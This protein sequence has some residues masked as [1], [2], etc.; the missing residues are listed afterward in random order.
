MRKHAKATSEEVVEELMVNNSVTNGLPALS[1]TSLRRVHGFNKLEPEPKDHIVVRYV[2]QFK[3]PLIL[4]LLGSAVLSV[5]VGQYEDALSIAAAVIIVGSV[6]FYQAS[7]SY[8]SCSMM[9]IMAE[10]LV[11]GDIVR[12]QSGDRVPADARIIVCNNLT[13]DESTLTGETE[14]RE[15]RSDPLPDLTD[16]CD[17]SSISNIAFM[18]TLI[19]SGNA[20]GIV[21]TTALET[22]FGKTFK[23]MKVQT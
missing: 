2:E 22:E 16:D 14:P 15:K 12:L 13:V 5:I 23:E 8:I 20:T 4:L 18:G 7:T 17:I 21:I 3:D 19:C 9:N 1:I 11:P 6:A 10:E